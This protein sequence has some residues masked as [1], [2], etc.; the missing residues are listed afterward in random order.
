M[1]KGTLKGSANMKKDSYSVSA[2][3]DKVFKQ[4][5]R[6][7]KGFTYHPTKGFKKSSGYIPEVFYI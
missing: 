6:G 5:F 1:T 4:G 3:G 7:M 2:S